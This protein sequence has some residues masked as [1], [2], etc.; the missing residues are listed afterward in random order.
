MNI[1]SAGLGLGVQLKLNKTTVF[2]NFLKVAVRNL[3]RNKF[4]S[5]I[6]IAGLAVGMASAILI[7][8]WIENELSYDRFHAK[9]DR[10]YQAWNRSVFD[11]KLQCW[12]T[13]PKIL[14]PT[15][16]KDYPE[17]EE[18]TR[19][20]WGNNF[21]FSL[22][23]K[24]MNVRGTMVDPGFLTIFDFPLVKG[25]Q[26]S[27]L[28]GIYSIVITEKLAR[29]LYGREDPMGKIIKV[30]NADNFTVTGVLKDFPN[31]TRF[32]DY[33]YLLPWEYLR[34]RGWS[35]SSWGNNSTSSYVLLKPNTSAAAFEKKIQNITID[36]TH[37]EE[38]IEVFIHPI[39]KWRLFSKF[40]N[41]KNAG[42]RIEVV[43]LFGFIAAFILLIACI[44]FMNLSTAR[45]EKRAKEVGIRK[46]VGAEK[47]SLIGQFLGESI[48]LALLAGIIAIG[49]VQL[50]LRGFNQLTDKELFIGYT[51]IYFW[52]AGLGFVIFT[53]I[54]AGSYPAFFLSSFRPIKVLKGTFKAAHALVTP[55]KVLVVIQFTFAIA[56]I[57]CTI[58]V[59]QQI[60]YAQDR[61]AGYNRDNLIY[62]FLEGDVEKN[63][64]LIKNE[65]L[66]SGA[67]SHVSKTS[68]PITE[69]WSDSWGYEWKGKDPNAKLDFNTFNTDGDLAKTV[70]LQIKEGRDIDP[71]VYLTDSTAIMLNESAVALMGLK[72]PIGE[73]VKYNETDWHVVGV[74]KDFILQSPYQPIKAMVIHGPKG[75]F[76]AMHIKLSANNST[77][78]NL[79]LAEQVFKK[80]NP[81]YPFQ[82]HFV[83]EEY[84]RKF[85][86]EERTATLAC[87]FAGLTIFI[88]CL[89]LFGLATYMAENRIKE[90]G[91]RKVLGASV[92]NITK[93]LSKDF[94]KLVI[95]ALAIAIPIGWLAMHYWLRN[96]PYRVNIEWWVFVSAGML[97]L[98]VA[99]LTVSYQ[100]I[101][102]GLANPVKSLRTE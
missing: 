38:K 30:D 56:L 8:L 51:N 64:T 17:V 86:D 16:K 71:K 81:E 9:K 14:A 66:S 39:T 27:A 92:I 78:R 11:G 54:I 94:L 12:S 20:N 41:G 5:I 82:Y 83:D 21:L 62:H 74:I 84:A 70:G 63:Y 100:S 37:G 75:W 2:K 1:Q 77:T 10:I 102:A 49:I 46:V 23:E 68:A 52:L 101:K 45:S 57:I 43:R 42:G 96:Y 33:E 53:G 28:N 79:K 80:Y 85:Q 95:I 31:N 48:L 58:I 55:R 4:F 76:N 67:A 22:G 29:K 13:T 98:L 34:K 26:R 59:M 44:N 40:E 32:Q 87:L 25:N 50:S 61:E 93:L 72:K 99:M 89:G 19:V 47:K 97:S 65:L 69:G 36:H 88:S 90:I 60:E 91:V 6:N 35:D 7:L 24:R 73:T 18:I 15:I 3:V